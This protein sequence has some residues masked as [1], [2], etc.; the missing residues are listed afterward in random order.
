MAYKKN[1]YSVKERLSYEKY[2]YDSLYEHY[3]CIDTPG[4]SFSP[5]V[6]KDLFNGVVIEDPLLMHDLSQGLLKDLD[7]ALKNKTRK[8]QT[9]LTGT[10][11]SRV[12]E[13]I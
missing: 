7:E 6:Q 1:L 12:I 3:E 11:L 4:S 9:E 2:F 13:V 5:Q 10:T 8:E